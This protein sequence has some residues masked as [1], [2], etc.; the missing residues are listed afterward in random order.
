MSENK[1]AVLI[2]CLF[3]IFVIMFFIVIGTI[4]NSCHKSP[5]E[6]QVTKPLVPLVIGNEWTY[7]TVSEK[8]GII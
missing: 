7:E 6:P 8:T 3:S 4:F 1:K 2:V 5:K